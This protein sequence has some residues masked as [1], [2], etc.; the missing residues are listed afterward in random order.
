M[1]I[2]PDPSAKMIHCRAGSA[3]CSLMATLVQLPGQSD[4][5]SLPS[6]RPFGRYWDQKPPA[7][8]WF[9][10]LRVSESG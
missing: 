4:E 3:Y 1:L 2:K 9:L 10:A 7:R 6:G 8:R 5:A